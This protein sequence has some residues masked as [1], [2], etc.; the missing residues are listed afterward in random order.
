MERARGSGGRAARPDAW[1]D[2]LLREIRPDLGQALE[3]CVGDGVALVIAGGDGEG[4]PEVRVRSRDAAVDELLELSDQAKEPRLKQIAAALLGPAQPRPGT[5]WCVV[6]GPAGSAL[7][8][9]PRP[10][11]RPEDVD[12]ARAQIARLCLDQR[13]L[14]AHARGAFAVRAHGCNVCAAWAMVLDELGADVR[15]MTAPDAGRAPVRRF[16]GAALCAGCVDDHRAV[17]A[18]AREELGIDDEQAL[19]AAMPRVVLER[20]D[21]ARKLALRQRQPSQG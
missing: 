14:G 5:L 20:L 21:P 13:G 3:R 15:A 10:L 4:R 18:L 1:H 19:A 16:G 2:R 12:R 7:R 11:T 8:A 6:I 17:V 9:I